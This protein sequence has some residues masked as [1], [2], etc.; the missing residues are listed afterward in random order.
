MNKRKGGHTINQTDDS[1]IH[2]EQLEIYGKNQSG[3]KAG[4][5]HRELKESK[6]CKRQNL[7]N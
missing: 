2:G 6:G 5:W 1:G 7:Q 4:C 3:P